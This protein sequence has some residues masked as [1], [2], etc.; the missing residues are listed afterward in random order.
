MPSKNGLFVHSDIF[1]VPKALC[2]PEWMGDRE[3]LKNVEQL[4]N[5]HKS[6]EENK[7]MLGDSVFCDF[8]CTELNVC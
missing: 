2:Q 6:T 8:R 5:R 3:P 1:P 7:Q 4:E